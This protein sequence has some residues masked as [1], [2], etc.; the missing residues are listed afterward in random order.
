[1]GGFC[2]G[3][4]AEDEEEEL[5]IL[6]VGS[7]AVL[8]FDSVDKFDKL[9]ADIGKLL[10]QKDF[11]ICRLCSHLPVCSPVKTRRCCCL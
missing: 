1:M 10:S 11:L 2:D 9:M 7:V 8:C 6:V 3:R 4:A 5:G